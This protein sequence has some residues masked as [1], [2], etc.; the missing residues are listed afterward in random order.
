MRAVWISFAA[1][2]FVTFL[3]ALTLVVTA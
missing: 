3:M 2:V 1:S